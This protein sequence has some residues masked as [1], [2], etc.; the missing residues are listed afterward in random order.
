VTFNRTGYWLLALF[1]GLGGIMLLVGLIAGGMVGG[2]F[3]M[4]GGIWF[5]VAGGLVLYNRQQGKKADHER[6]LYEHGL[7]GTGTVVETSSNT[8]IND[9]PVLKMVLDLNIPGHHPRRIHKRIL[10]SRFAAYR[11]QPGVVLPVHA[12]PDP[13]KAGDVLVRW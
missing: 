3:A 13:Q 12:N 4:I 1:G 11:M 5:L 7:A 9:E 6:W 8:T 10:M 2:I